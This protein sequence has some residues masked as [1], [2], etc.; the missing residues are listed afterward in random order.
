[1]A[2]ARTLFDCNDQMRAELAG[3]ACG[4]SKLRQHTSRQARPQVFHKLVQQPNDRVRLRDRV[5]N[6][7]SAMF[8]LRPSLRS[9]RVSLGLRH[10][11]NSRHRN[12]VVR[13]RAPHIRLDHTQTDVRLAP[14]GVRIEPDSALLTMA[15]VGLGFNPD[16]TDAPPQLAAEHMDTYR[17][18]PMGDRSQVLSNSQTL[19]LKYLSRPW[20]SIG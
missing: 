9:R 3:E 13:W 7:R 20:G 18:I 19:S 6:L 11:Q 1:M 2:V 5:A 17:V 4:I 12:S 10:M 14:P 8:G 15:R 16:T